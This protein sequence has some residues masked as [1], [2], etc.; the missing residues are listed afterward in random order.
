MLVMTT[1]VIFCSMLKPSQ[2]NNSISDAVAKQNISTKSHEM[3]A[4]ISQRITD[5][6]SLLSDSSE[7]IA[8]IAEMTASRGIS[9]TNSHN[10]MTTGMSEMAK[11]NGTSLINN[12]GEM[13]VVRGPGTT[14]RGVSP[15][16]SHND[17]TTGMSEM[18][19]GSGTSP[20]NNRGEM[21]VVRGPGTTSRGISSTNIEITAEIPGM[22]TNRG[23]SATDNP[24][25]NERNSSENPLQTWNLSPCMQ[26]VADRSFIIMT[27][28]CNISF[29]PYRAFSQ[30]PLAK[31][32]W[33][34]NTTILP[35]WW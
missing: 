24:R 10:D 34:R 25:G 12:R 1:L 29:I 11:G 22:T 33:H 2:S 35:G 7:M 13:T 14:S 9:P 21:T 28:Y 32:G 3:T 17:M 18:A 16:Y 4:E 15:T 19:K 26:P 20:I 23:T 6:W 8:E 30:F 27:V 31:V 5:T